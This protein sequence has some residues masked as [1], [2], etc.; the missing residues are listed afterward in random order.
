MECLGLL[1]Y[2]LGSPFRVY[3]TRSFSFELGCINGCFNTS[4]STSSL[5][6]FFEP[7]LIGDFFETSTW[8]TQT[9]PDQYMDGISYTMLHM[10][11][12]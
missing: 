7:L 8:N 3:T 2:T 11:G 5:T 10:D 12:P 6:R 4:S 9:I 1:D